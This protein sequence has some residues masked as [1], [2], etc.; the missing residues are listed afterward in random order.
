MHKQKSARTWRDLGT[1]QDGGTDGGVAE[2]VHKA[3]RM[4]S[5]D[6]GCARSWCVEPTR[7]AVCGSWSHLIWKPLPMRMPCL[8]GDLDC[9]S[10][11]PHR[12]CGV[13]PWVNQDD[14]G[15]QEMLDVPRCWAKVHKRQRGLQEGTFP[16]PIRKKRSFKAQLES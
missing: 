13:E 15:C 9:N 2:M 12:D 3:T 8:R 10:V 7:K 4:F 6:M 14:K 1:G 11:G 5:A 16:T